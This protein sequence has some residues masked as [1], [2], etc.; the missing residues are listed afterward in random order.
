MGSLFTHLLADSDKQLVLDLDF[1]KHFFNYAEAY[2]L[3]MQKGDVD[4]VK[5]AFQ[6][7]EKLKQYDISPG[8]VYNN[9]NIILT[10]FL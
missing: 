10:I 7:V 3:G 9:S 4:F 5:L 1:F 2:R 6:M 8:I